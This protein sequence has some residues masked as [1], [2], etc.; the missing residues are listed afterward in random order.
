MRH[1][2]VKLRGSFD[3]ID[4]AAI[5]PQPDTSMPAPIGE[6]DRPR[7]LPAGDLPD[8]HATPRILP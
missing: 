4:L 2:Q 7:A 1:E 8:P 5:W 6:L 3:I